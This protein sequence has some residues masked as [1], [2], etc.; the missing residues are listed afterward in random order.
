MWKRGVNQTK[1]TV[2]PSST[3][4]IICGELIDCQ[5]SHHLGI[6]SYDDNEFPVAVVADL[7]NSETVAKKKN[8]TNAEDSGLESGHSSMNTCKYQRTW[9]LKMVLLQFCL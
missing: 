1:A 5:V 4:E 3:Q 8:E 7:I 6:Y 2:R 9:H